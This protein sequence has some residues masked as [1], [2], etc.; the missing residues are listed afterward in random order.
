MDKDE[1]VSSFFTNISQV[2][3]HLVSI[4]VG[5]DEDDLLQTAIDGIP[6]SW[7]TLLETINVR[8]ENPNFEIL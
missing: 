5:T 7:E 8:E 2:K 3:N 4:S 1:T 6:F